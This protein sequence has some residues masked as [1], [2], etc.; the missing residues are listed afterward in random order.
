MK[1]HLA[2]VA[3]GL[4]LALSLSTGCSGPKAPDAALVADA[5]DAGAL[6]LEALDAAEV[7]Y[8][9]SLPVPTAEDI[10]R[11]ESHAQMIV[12]ARKQLSAAKN[13]ITSGN[14][15][16]ARS[17]LHAALLDMSA[18]ASELRDLG[19][20]LPIEVSRG[21]DLLSTA[22]ALLPAPAS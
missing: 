16:T 3:L 15:L 17:E 22:V 10:A 19:V 5:F 14:L 21:L 18:V 4:C 7:T 1:R 9:D 6:A 12:D 2:A 20:K 13:D 8:L 11:A